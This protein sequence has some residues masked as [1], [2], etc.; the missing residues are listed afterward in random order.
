MAK[1]KLKLKQ[2]SIKDF[3]V[4]DS[5]YTIN[6]H[7]F[8]VVDDNDKEISY[9]IVN[10]NDLMFSPVNNNNG[11]SEKVKEQP[12]QSKQSKT[13]EVENKQPEVTNNTVE[14]EKDVSKTD[15]STSEKTIKKSKSKKGSYSSKKVE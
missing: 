5:G 14:N 4:T 15:D 12:K 10:R 11:G 9:Y 13:K 3:L 1:I 7:D 2:N 6:K 8:T